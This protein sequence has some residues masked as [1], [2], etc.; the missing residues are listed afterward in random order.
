MKPVDSLLLAL[1]FSILER[2]EK[3]E[4]SD[5]II[6]IE[7][8]NNNII[9]KTKLKEKLVIK[10]PEVLQGDKGDRGEQG[11]QGNRGEQGAQG[12]AGLT[13]E[14]GEKG[15]KGLK[16]KTGSKGDKGE[17]GNHGDIGPKGDKGEI[18][19]QGAPGEKGDQGARG[20]SIIDIKFDKRN[21]LIIK[22]DD[23][24]FD[25][26]VLKRKGGGGGASEEFI[27]TNSLPMPFAVGGLKVGTVFNKM[28]LKE[29]FTK[30]FY[31]YNYPSFFEFFID[32]IPIELEVGQEIRSGVSLFHWEIANPE[33]LLENSIKIEYTNINLLLA[34]ELSNTGF[35]DIDIPQISFNSPT[36]ITF[37]ISAKDTTDVTFDKFY[38]IPVKGRV[39]IGESTESIMSQGVLNSLRIRNLQ[40][41]ING[42]YVLNDGG[43]KW[44]CYPLFMGMR[45]DFYDIDMQEAIAMEQQQTINIIND[46]GVAQDYLCYRSYNILNGNIRIGIK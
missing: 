34:D 16:G 25:L 22:T 41:D 20:N 4:G 37:K 18:G 40:D 35:Y 31:G 13:G 15:D 2:L 36:I 14:K 11:A 8:E 39:F 42:E 28:P 43:Y 12:E 17:K 23:K 44:F 9:I 46:Y 3:L 1:Q 6:D 26:G 5:S 32:G 33:F 10:V 45:Y 7:V 21:H 38:S 30:L 19:E 27:Y 24:T 29:I